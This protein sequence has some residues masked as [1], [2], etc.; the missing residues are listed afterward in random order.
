MIRI[1]RLILA[2]LVAAALA[3]ACGPGATPSASAPV[4]SAPASGA[5]GGSQAATDCPTEGPQPMA[6][7]EKRVVT[8]DTEKGPIEITVEADLGPL[9]AENFV[10]LAACGFYDGIVFHRVVPGFVI[11]GGDPTGSGSGGPGYEFKNDP[12]SVPYDRGV[13]AMANAGRDTNGS[14]FFIV[15]QDVPEA[16]LPPDYSV[17]G[18]VTKGMEAVDAIAAAADAENPTNPIKM[19]RVSVQQP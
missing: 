16:N 2:L 9:A 18:R 6:G 4:T 14:Q 19:D 1:P 8:I 3:V 17:F 13:V 5:P 12:V 7:G 15:L 11:Q 10:D